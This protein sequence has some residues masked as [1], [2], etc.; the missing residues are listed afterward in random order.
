M[1]RSRVWLVASL[2]E[3]AMQDIST[4]TESFSGGAAEGTWGHEFQSHHI[5]DLLFDLIL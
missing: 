2:L 4:S 1:L 5:R 3:T